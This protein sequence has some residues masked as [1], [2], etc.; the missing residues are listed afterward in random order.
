MVDTGRVRNPPWHRE[1]S[2]SWSA[3]AAAPQ[4]LG[5]RAVHRQSEQILRLCEVRDQASIRDKV[6][7]AEQVEDKC[8]GEDNV[9]NGLPPLCMARSVLK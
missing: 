6:P 3:P 4:R 1:V 8:Q 9:E 7:Q 2:P 5:W